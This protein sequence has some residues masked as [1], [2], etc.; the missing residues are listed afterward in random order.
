M[1]AL[2]DFKDVGEPIKPVLARFNIY[3]ANFNAKGGRGTCLG[4][5]EPGCLELP[6]PKA[7]AV[8][9][10]SYGLSQQAPELQGQK[11]LQSDL[12]ILKYGWLPT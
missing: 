11:E 4:R 6:A 2:E 10:F 1:A 3:R 12:R 5:W 9:P 8:R 7:D